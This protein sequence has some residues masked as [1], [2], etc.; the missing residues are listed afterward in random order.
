[1]RGSRQGHERTGEHG[2]L[3]Q[4]LA[5]NDQQ[6]GFGADVRVEEGP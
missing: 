5:V 3:Q 2:A 6:L 4:G 1:M